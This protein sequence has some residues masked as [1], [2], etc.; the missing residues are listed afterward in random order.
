[1]VN[2]LKSRLV[3]FLS[4]FLFLAV[5]TPQ[6]FA[7]DVINGVIERSPTKLEESRMRLCRIRENMVAKRMDRLEAFVDNMIAKFDA[8]TARVKAFYSTRVVAKDMEVEGY[9]Q[10]VSDVDT[11]KIAV[12]TAFNEAKSAGDTFTCEGDNPNET[13][14]MYHEN[15]RGVKDALKTYRTSVRNLITAVHSVA[16]EAETP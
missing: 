14:R 5:L 16:G 6:T 7:K 3:A 9:D 1:M 10:L 2:T 11:A 15:M 12:Q 4:I 8:I 13:L